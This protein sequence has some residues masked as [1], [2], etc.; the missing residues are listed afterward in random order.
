MGEDDRKTP[1]VYVRFFLHF[2]FTLQPQLKA[3]VFL[4]SPFDVTPSGPA[5]G[6]RGDPRSMVSDEFDVH[7]TDLTPLWS[8]KDDDEP[9][10]F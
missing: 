7:T 2:F 6:R 8:G 5:Y 9:T 3:L 10:A 4:Q 1:G